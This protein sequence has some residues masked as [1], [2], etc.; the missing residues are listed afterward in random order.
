MVTNP[1][2]NTIWQIKNPEFW[3]IFIYELK[4]NNCPVEFLSGCILVTVPEYE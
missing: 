4:T 2:G 3:K 1:E